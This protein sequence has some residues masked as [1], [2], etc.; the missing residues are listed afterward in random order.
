MTSGMPAWYNRNVDEST[1]VNEV[2]AEPSPLTLQE[3]AFR[4][5]VKTLDYR[6]P[7]GDPIVEQPADLDSFKMGLHQGIEKLTQLVPPEDPTAFAIG[8]LWMHQRAV[9]EQINI[10]T[11]AIAKVNGDTSKL[12]AKLDEYA[13]ALP[14][15]DSLVGRLGRWGGSRRA[16]QAGDPTQTMHALG[17]E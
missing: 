14:D 8:Q 11:T 16:R 13:D 17:A 5:A 15:P 12:V 3:Q 6:D 9:A 7:Q 10:L 2:P 1:M 4:A